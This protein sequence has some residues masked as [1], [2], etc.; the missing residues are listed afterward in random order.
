MVTSAAALIEVD[1]VLGFIFGYDGIAGDKVT[2][3]R[4]VGRGRLRND[5]NAVPRPWAAV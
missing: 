4:P 1:R 5:S 3:G 2:V